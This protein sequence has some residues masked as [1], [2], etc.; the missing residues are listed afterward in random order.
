MQIN[1]VNLVPE[2]KRENFLKFKED[3]NYNRRNPD[4]IG[5]SKIRMRI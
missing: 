2:R 4:P 5:I 3:E 1:V